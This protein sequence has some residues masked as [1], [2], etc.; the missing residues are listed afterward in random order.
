MGFQ[1][2]KEMELQL[3]SNCL[4]K[5]HSFKIP[6]M[7]TVELSTLVKNDEFL[8]QLDV[9]ILDYYRHDGAMC[10][11]TANNTLYVIPGDTLV[12]KL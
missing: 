11:C 7:G 3:Q 1:E 12:H 5:Q 4:A 9:Y 8:Y 10:R 2:E 6:E